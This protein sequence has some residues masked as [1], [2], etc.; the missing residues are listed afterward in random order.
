[1]YFCRWSLTALVCAN[2]SSSVEMC[3]NASECCASNFSCTQHKYGHFAV[4]WADAHVGPIKTKASLVQTVTSCNLHPFKQPRSITATQKSKLYIDRPDSS[5]VGQYTQGNQNNLTYF[6]IHSRI[7]NSKKVPNNILSMCGFFC[8]VMHSLLSLTP[9][10]INKN[11]SQLLYSRA[12]IRL[13][14]ASVLCLIRFVP[15]CVMELWPARPPLTGTSATVCLQGPKNILE[16]HL[17]HL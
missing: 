9:K 8:T 1:M 5:V 15:V 12:D 13:L 14:A 7:F 10:E 6:Q 11:S 17:P 2:S 4:F 3:L 16:A